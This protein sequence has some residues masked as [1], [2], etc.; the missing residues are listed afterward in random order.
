MDQT[1]LET[2]LAELPVPSVRYFPTLDSTNDEAWRWVEAGAPDGALVI[3]EE[4]TAG[5][6]RFHRHWVT[7]ARSSLAFS[8]V[9]LLPPIDPHFYSRLTGV[10]ALAVCQ[11]FRTLYSLPALVKWPNDILVNERKAGGVLVEARWS[12]EDLVAAVIGIGINIAPESVS[13][14]VLPPHSLS[15]SATCIEGAL[16]HPVDRMELLHTILKEFFGWLPRLTSSEFMHAWEDLLAYRGQWVELSAGEVGASQPTASRSQVITGKL[17]GL[18]E[19]GSLQLQV[20]AG[21]LL[22]VQVGD[23]RLRPV[24]SPPP[25]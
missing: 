11:A 24:L 25:D 13:P 12:G 16:G 18:D 17:I 4:Q 21:E 6:G 8:L 9:L 2:T 20:Y 23:V 3:A 1:S 5:R 14:D 19:D 10:G 22:T 7:V 15:F